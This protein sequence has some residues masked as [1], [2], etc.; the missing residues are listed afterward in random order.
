L[1]ESFKRQQ[2]IHKAYFYKCLHLGPF[3][4]ARFVSR[5]VVILLAVPGERL[6]AARLLLL[7]LVGDPIAKAIGLG[8]VEK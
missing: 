3:F 8:T 7:Q 4:D 5:R 1:E 2:Y 6:A